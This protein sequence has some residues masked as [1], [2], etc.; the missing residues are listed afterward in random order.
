MTSYSPVTIRLDPGDASRLADLAR[1][2]PLVIDHYA[3]RRC[4][5]TIGDLRV[6]FADPEPSVADDLVELDPVDDVRV[7]AERD[8][9]LLLAT[10][11]SLRLAGGLGG[12]RV[13]VDLDQPEAWL[14]FL[15]SH[16]KS[17]R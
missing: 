12:S 1:D 5:V 14:A 15:E 4:G 16:P 8:L 7:L 2:R 6:R 17:R 11:A 3:S 9:L 10:G 13:A